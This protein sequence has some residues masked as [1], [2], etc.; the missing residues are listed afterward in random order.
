MVPDNFAIEWARF[1]VTCPQCS[2]SAATTVGNS[3][4][5]LRCQSCGAAIDLK[6]AHVTVARQEAAKRAF[7][8]ALKDADG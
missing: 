5:A 3:R 2:A 8:R 4:P 7:E 6:S 1:S